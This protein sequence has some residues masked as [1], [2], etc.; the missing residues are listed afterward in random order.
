PTRRRSEPQLTR[1]LTGTEADAIDHIDLYAQIGS[2]TVVYNC[3]GGPETGMVALLTPDGARARKGLHPGYKTHYT[4]PSWHNADDAPVRGIEDVPAWAARAAVGGCMDGTDRGRYKVVR[5]DMP[6]KDDM[7]LISVDD[8][9][10]EKPELW[11]ERLPKKFLEVGPRI[12]E[13]DG[14]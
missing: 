10:I 13:A 9:L 12:I 14:T 5:R 4:A 8:H 7:Q 6:L 2:W 3:S 1:R 11:Q